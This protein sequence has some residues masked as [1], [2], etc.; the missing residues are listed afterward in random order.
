MPDLP[1]EIEVPALFYPNPVK[2][3]TAKLYYKL[4]ERADVSIMLYNFSAQLIYSNTIAQVPPGDHTEQITLAN[5]TPGFYI[6]VLK[7]RGKPDQSFK[8]IVQ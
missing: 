8:I 6:C 7:V 2:N 3:N 4:E 1:G 5:A